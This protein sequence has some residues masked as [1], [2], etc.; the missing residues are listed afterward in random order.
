M[1]GWKFIRI[2]TETG[3]DPT[4]PNAVSFEQ[5]PRRELVSYASVRMP[6]EFLLSKRTALLLN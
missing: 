1:H 4:G 2:A 3:I 6:P 5:Q